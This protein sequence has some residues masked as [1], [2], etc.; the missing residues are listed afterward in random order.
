MSS[1]ASS[2]AYAGLL[3]DETFAAALEQVTRE[4]TPSPAPPVPTGDLRFPTDHTELSVRL[5]L[6]IVELAR[7]L[8]V[9]GDTL[10]R[11]ADTPGGLMKTFLHQVPPYSSS[12]T[13]L[14]Q[15]IDA[16]VAATA[17]R[18]QRTNEILTQIGSPFGYYA[19]LLKI[20]VDSH[21]KTFELFETAL[22]AARLTVM[23]LKAHFKRGRPA[24]YSAIIAPLIATPGHAAYPAGHAAQCHLVSALLRYIVQSKV[25]HAA[26]LLEAL[27]DRIAGNRV[28]AGLH[29][30]EDNIAGKAVGVALASV[31]VGMP[32]GTR[33]AE[34]IEDVGREWR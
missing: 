18:R 21:P 29:F 32:A 25:P 5:E 12:G 14:S 33:I 9:I 34:L 11:L 8:V 22:L 15:Q 13:P 28:V 24:Q 4:I 26:Q 19:S 30:P 7:H 6:N 23:P 1:V 20:A 16:V 27:A 2:F 3:R 31:F 10:Y 17:L